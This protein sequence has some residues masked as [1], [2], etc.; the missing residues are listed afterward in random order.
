MKRYTYKVTPT[1]IHGMECY[2]GRLFRDEV[3]VHE[4]TC[5]SLGQ[6]K[7]SCY[8]HYVRLAELDEIE[9]HTQIVL[10]VS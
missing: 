10:K 7:A 5:L 8:R 9:E 6:A 4:T 3:Q 1:S 2:V